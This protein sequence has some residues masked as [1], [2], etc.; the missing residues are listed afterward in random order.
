MLMSYVSPLAYV[1]FIGECFALF[2]PVVT[3]AIRQHLKYHPT[4]M[5]GSILISLR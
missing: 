3:V 2:S 1:H 4:V 5:K